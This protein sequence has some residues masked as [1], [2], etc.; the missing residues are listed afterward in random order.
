LYKYSKISNCLKKIAVNIST[1]FLGTASMMVFIVTSQFYTLLFFTPFPLNNEKRK[2]MFKKLFMW[3]PGFFVRN[4][5][6]IKSLIINE[7]KEDFVKPAIIVCN[8]QSVIEIPM[9]LGVKEKLLIITNRSFEKNPM[10]FFIGRYM[11]NYIVSD[12]VEESVDYLREKVKNGYSIIFYAEALKVIEG[13][14]QRYHKGAFYYSERLG[15]DILPVIFLGTGT[16]VSQKWFYLKKGKTFMKVL[17]RISNSDKSFGNDYSERSK[18]IFH[19]VR[20]EFEALKSS[21]SP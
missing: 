6:N 20:N 7:Q 9:L 3:Y 16:V 2:R 10:M 21:V 4:H 15:L 1:F 17:P 12:K 18:T 19:H 11:E 14:I 8:R 13:K 5:Y